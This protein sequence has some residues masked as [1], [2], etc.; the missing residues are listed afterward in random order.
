MFD[1]MIACAIPSSVSETDHHKVMTSSWKTD[2]IRS[3]FHGFNQTN[4]PA[5]KG[6]TPHS[7]I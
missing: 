1:R 3:L 4:L 7:K 5:Q 6:G 2:K